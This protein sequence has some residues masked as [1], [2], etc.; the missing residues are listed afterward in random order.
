[1]CYGPCFGSITAQANDKDHEQAIYYLSRTMIGA[2]F[3]YNPI[4]KECLALVFAVQ[5]MRHYLIR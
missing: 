1:M 5:K 4:K 2:K 3:R